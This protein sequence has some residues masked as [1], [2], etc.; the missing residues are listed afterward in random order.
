MASLF[1]NISSYPKGTQLTR[2][3]YKHHNNP[4]ERWHSSIAVFSAFLHPLLNEHDQI[5]RIGH[6]LKTHLCLLLTAKGDHVEGTAFTETLSH[7]NEEVG[8]KENVPRL[9][10]IEKSDDIKLHLPLFL[11]I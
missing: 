6:L 3:T 9:I 10:F 1:G 8:I 7:Q 2:L 5:L 11:S 4:S